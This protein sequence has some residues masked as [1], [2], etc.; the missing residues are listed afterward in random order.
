MSYVLKL[1]ATIGVTLPAALLTIFFGLFDPNGKFVYGI[2]RIWSRT[3]LRFTGV[4]VKVQG[5]TRIDSDRQYVFMVN[6]QS[7][8]D[9]PVLV[10]SLSSFQL[11]W[12]AKRELLWVPLF[13]WAMWAAKHIPVDR[14][15]LSDA[16][17]SFKR[18]QKRIE[19]GIS[20]VVFPEGTRS[21]DGNLLPFK[22]GGFLLA[23]KT[24]A[25]IVPVTIRGSGKILPKGNWR[26][27]R[28][29]ITVVVGDPIAVA[30]Y[31]PGRLRPLVEQV[32]AII[33]KNL[34]PTALA[35]EKCSEKEIS[36]AEAP[37]CQGACLCR[38]G[39]QAGRQR[40]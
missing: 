2:T 12:I 38:H 32:R 27:R 28:G 6:H 22:R 18:A 23:A 20:L 3:I 14:G 4:S 5:L 15:D 37:A 7:N 35:G 31:R 33:A 30:S 17:L 1:V 24:Q 40:R 8:L 39:R 16:V 13:G 11:R 36:R 25:P 29:V 10:W 21:G 34:E 19:S 26:I 9:I